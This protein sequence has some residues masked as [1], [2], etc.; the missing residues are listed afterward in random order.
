L[1]SDYVLRGPAVLPQGGEGG[2]PEVSG[3][4]LP[5]AG[6]PEL[7]CD[8]TFQS[9][10]NFAVCRAEYWGSAGED[11]IRA[12]AI[13]E[14]GAVIRA[15]RSASPG[16]DVPT[17]ELP[18]ATSGVIESVDSRGTALR[19]ARFGSEVTALVVDAS[20]I[21][22]A[23]D[24][25]VVVL[26]EDLRQAVV[27]SRIGA[28]SRLAVS[29]AGM[30][31]LMSDGR[32]LALDQE[33][34]PLHELPLD[35]ARA[36]DV[37]IDDSGTVFVTGSK[38][39]AGACLGRMPFVRAFDAAGELSQ[40]AYDFMDAPDWCASSVGRRLLLRGGKLYY[41]GEQQGGNS[42]HLRDPHDLSLQA[43]LVSYDDFSSGAG[44][45]I[46]VYTFVGRFDAT[47]LEL[48]AGQV[49]LPR[50]AGVGGSLSANALAVDAAG[51]LF[52]ASIS[53]CCIEAR[54]ERTVAGTLLGPYAGPELSLLILSADLRERLTWTTFTGQGATSGLSVSALGVGNGV[55]VLAVNVAAAGGLLT[56]PADLEAPGSADAYLVTFPTP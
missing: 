2:A 27:D 31:A 21:V 1:R 9:G 15:G 30:A 26:S 32:V 14:A 22:A 49:V 4:G 43:P 16:D 45:A 18:G 36:E 12:V 56:V 6:A 34:A 37:A 40:T 19:A 48:E 50:E 47:T 44:K 51:R 10:L 20:N 33:A 41:A 55:G 39:A 46:D 35:G 42:V 29:P 23:S 53:S 25:G 38:A 17:L 7:E 11:E 3:G 24:L 8:A 52:L 5:S 54:D 13:S 28:V